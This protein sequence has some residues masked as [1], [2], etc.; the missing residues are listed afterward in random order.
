MGAQPKL[1]ILNPTSKVPDEIIG[2]AMNTAFERSNKKIDIDFYRL[3][4]DPRGAPSRETISSGD[5]QTL[6]EW[7]KIFYSNGMNIEHAIKANFNP[8]GLKAKKCFVDLLT[9]S[10]TGTFTAEQRAFLMEWIEKVPSMWTNA[11]AG[12]VPREM[13]DMV[14][15]NVFGNFSPAYADDRLYEQMGEKRF[16]T[17]LALQGRAAEFLL[18]NALVS[19]ELLLPGSVIFSNKPFDTTKGHIDASGNRV[20][21]CT[22]LTTPRVYETQESRFLGNLPLAVLRQRYSENSGKAGAV[23]ITV[24]DNGGGGQ[25]VSM[26]NI[27]EVAE[28]AKERGMLVWIDACRIFEN[29]EM[30]KLY[31]PG[32]EN[33]S[34]AD[35]VKEMLSHAD[36]VTMSFKKM[37]SDCGGAVLITKKSDIVGGKLEEVRKTIM[38]RTTTNYGNGFDSYCGLTGEGMIKIISGIFTAMDPEVIGDRIV[39]VNSAYKTLK[40][41]GV[42]VV[43]GGHALYFAAD[44]ILPKVPDACCPAETLQAIIHA[45]EAM[46]GCGLGNIVYGEYEKN[47]AGIYTLVGKPEMDSLRYAIPRLT[48]PDTVLNF[49]FNIIGKAYREGLLSDIENGMIAQNYV[50]DGFYH[51]SGKYMPVNEA[52]FMK[53]IRALQEFVQAHLV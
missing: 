31:E 33:K 47:D 21:S 48:Y 9:D 45:A 24:T 29:A 5:K 37:Y 14:M 49:M 41:Y 46:R 6:I 22:P 2:K 40:Q 7:M 32:Y 30:I 42:P 12:S 25:P 1:F 27:R 8:F 11:Y 52:E 15:E 23:L 51:F 28:F 50:K 19:A 44:Q 13:F 36:V 34:L 39:Q 18:L 38:Q 4:M 17:H 43:G 16:A 35:I 26:Q 20:I 10:G 53:K 3:M